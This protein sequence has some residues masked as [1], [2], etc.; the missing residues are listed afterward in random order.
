MARHRISRRGFLGVSAAAAG[1]AVFPNLNLGA[2]AVSSPMKRTFGRTGFDVTTLGLGGQASIQWT[3]K[4]VDPTAIILKT[5]EHGVNY[6][7]TSNAYGPSQIN[8]GKAF[9][10]IDLI[11][12]RAGYDERRRR[13]LFIVSKTMIRYAKGAARG[14]S[15]RTD[16]PRGSRAADDIKRSLSQLFGDGQG[17]YP[18]GAYLDVFYIHNLNTMEEIDAIYEGLERPDPNS[19]RI[20]ALA[21]LRD[22]R[23]G[24]NLTG[25]NPGEEKLIRGIGISGHSSSPVMME[26][27]QRDADDNLIDAMLIAI[28]ANDRRYLSH[29]YNV[30]PVAAAKNVGIVGMKVFSD[31]AMYTKE[32][33]WSFK[34][35]DVVLSV[36]SPQLP[37]R[38]LVEYTLTTPGVATAIIGIGQIDEDS[39]RCQLTQNLSAAQVAP[40]SFSDTDR[41]SIEQLAETAGKG[42]SNW[43]Q[44]DAQALGAPRDAAAV[45]ADKMV[46]L[47]WHSAFAADRPLE[48]YEIRRNGE[49]IGAVPHQPQTTK[50]PFTFEDKGAGGNGQRYTIVSIDKG[51][52][53][54]ATE[55]ITPLPS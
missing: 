28:N 7:D 4:G 55:A 35:D 44:N 18:P 26:C 38:P 6:I 29:Q 14:I 1:A 53:T 45:H 16:G 15:D 41:E 39:G 23:D 24:T 10:E 37:S 25:L 27:L 11:P 3:P 34:P 47:T 31:G 36:G 21:A 33:R 8:F 32:P 13:E 43:F 40:A 48:K 54:T 20:G 19:E 12:G 46:R 50:A 30:I 42:R 49:V 2:L 17:N 52:K 22:F 5:L 51:G 9:R